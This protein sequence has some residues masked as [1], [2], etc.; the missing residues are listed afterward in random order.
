MLVKTQLE[1]EQQNLEIIINKQLAMISKAQR[2]GR[3]GD[4]RQVRNVLPYYI[5]ELETKLSVYLA[6][7][8]SGKARVKPVPAKVLT[9]LPPR[10]VAH[11]VIKSVLNHV[12]QKIDT[13]TKLYTY[14]AR[15]LEVEYNMTELS[16]RSPDDF[17]I[18]T[19][20]MD[21]N[22]Y[23]GVRLTKVLYDLMHKYNKQF[24]SL[25]KLPP[26]MQLAQVA[27]HLLA[28]CQPLVDG[29]FAPPL[30]HI[31]TLSSSKAGVVKSKTKI[32]IADWLL[33]WARLQ[34][35]EGNLLPNYLTPL[36]EPPKPW[37]DMRTGGFHSER[38]RASFIKTNVAKSRFDFNSM[39]RTVQAVN[40]LQETPWEINKEVL[41][42]MLYAFR[43]RL[44]WGGLAAPQEVSAPPYPHPNR[45]REDLNEEELKEV[46]A[47]ISH[48][49]L[50]H[51][52]FHSEHSRYLAL[53]RVLNEAQ[54]FSNYEKIFFAYQVDFR[55]RIYPMVANL[56]PQGAG[57]V[58][59]LLRFHNGLPIKDKLSENYLCV[60]GANTFGE[61]KLRMEQ[62]VRWVLDNEQAI[63]DS[64]RDPIQSDF[65]KQA[66]SP[67]EF[68]A[69]CFEWNSY[70]T[71]PDSFVS[72]LP[73]A[74]DGSC[75]GL[76]HLSAMMRD[77]VGGRAVNLTANVNKGDIYNDVAILAQERLN[78]EAK[79]A[80]EEWK[81]KLAEFGITRATCK[82]PVMIVPY[83]GT[84]Q[85][86]KEYV[87]DD[88]SDRGIRNVLDLQDTK[89]A[90]G[91]SGTIIWDA[92]GQV[93]IK[94]REVMTWF[95]K[96]ARIAAKYRNDNCIEWRTPNGFHIIQC[97]VKMQDRLYQT[98]LGDKIPQRLSMRLR[99]E[100]EEND[101]HGHANSVSPN[102][103]H[104]LDACALQE[105]VLRCFEDYGIK[106]FAMIHDSY[107]THAANTAGLARA[108][109]EVFVSLYK[110]NDVIKDWINSQPVASRE[111]FPE[112]P[113][114][115]TL[116]LDE[117]L[118]S[119]HFFS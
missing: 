67:W 42:V 16:E 4:L 78:R 107:G 38:L 6:E 9:L 24:I 66:D 81:K 27:V 72:R 100:T 20:F 114:R 82:R 95:K 29:V 37:T 48:K 11:F 119:E 113:A 28:D 62:K 71:N 40:T 99:E 94:G 103:I 26:L 3:V 2:I 112:L 7:I 30:V 58:K 50:L 36:I 106:D 115:G 98:R 49:A 46:K 23:H 57:Y 17:E 117:I 18:I 52:E 86:C 44:S 110:S 85:A 14:I 8:M 33:D 104:S 19:K 10:V 65:W 32:I 76:Q 56:S 70:R 73:I 87:G 108:L 79:S 90:I 12:G 34:T 64:A 111:K 80:T 47:W 51:D 97:K 61:D 118:D 31:A 54:R 5:D 83:A 41:E 89:K 92:I 13:G 59:S 91:Y 55:G 22:K 21:K 109:R 60:Q 35:E 63:F 84:I 105:T 1:L 15:Q 74:L 102:F 88:F 45:R 116:D 53:N 101:L 68:L 25:D 43:N 93:I 96:S 39:K 75:N 69:F 77:A